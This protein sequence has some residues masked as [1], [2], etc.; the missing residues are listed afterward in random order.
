MKLFKVVENEKPVEA[1]LFDI[2]DWIIEAYPNDI[3]VKEPAMI[4]EL[5]LTA[6]EIKKAKEAKRG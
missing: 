1:G 5:V 2:C 3:F 6:K 4:I